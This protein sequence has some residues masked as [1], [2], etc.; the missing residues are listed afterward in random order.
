MIAVVTSV[1]KNTDRHFSQIIL[2]TKLYI[3]FKSY[4][5]SL[6]LYRSIVSFWNFDGF[7][8]EAYTCSYRGKNFLLA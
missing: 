5:H 2:P 4:K 6:N 7:K 1:V 3:I 8:F